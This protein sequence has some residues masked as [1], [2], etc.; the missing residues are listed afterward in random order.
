L[1]GMESTI[2]AMQT[3]KFWKIR[4][5]WFNFKQRLGIEKTESP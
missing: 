4:Q 3:S 5:Q 1:A 2:T